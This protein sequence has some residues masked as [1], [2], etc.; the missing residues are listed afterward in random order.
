LLSVAGK[1]SNEVE[2]TKLI[3]KL[4]TAGHISINDKNA[5]TYHV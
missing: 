1:A 3:E 2:I 5:V 4:S